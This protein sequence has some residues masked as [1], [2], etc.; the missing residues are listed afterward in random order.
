MR[1]EPLK[2]R[3]VADALERYIER[4]GLKTGDQL[5]TEAHLTAVFGVNRHT[6]R[7]ALRV[8][9]DSGRLEARQGRG[10]FLRLPAIPYP[11]REFPRFSRLLAD[12]GITPRVEVKSVGLRKGTDLELLKLKLREGSKVIE[13]QRQGFAET[14]PVS[15][16]IHVFPAN[17]LARTP[18]EASAWRSVTEALRQSGIHSFRRLET[19][20][21]ARLPTAPE[22]AES[23][24][25]SF[26]KFQ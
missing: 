2:W 9:E 24:H 15:Q 19:Q 16:S 23:H 22:R 12:L 26:S 14:L 10:R 3:R 20:I 7:R 1:S 17:R 8:L 11:L 18:L 21:T 13:V 5:P 4:E 6:L 25:I